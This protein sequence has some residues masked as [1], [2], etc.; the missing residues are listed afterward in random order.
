VN[1]G[2]DVGLAR[3]KDAEILEWALAN[4]S[5]AVTLDAD[6]REL[7]A[8]GA[9][10]APSVIRLR[11]QGLNADALC[12]VVLAVITS[13]ADPIARGAA[14]TANEHQARVRLLPIRYTQ[15]LRSQIWLISLRPRLGMN[16]DSS[17]KRR[18]S[19]H[20]PTEFAVHPVDVARV[21]V[22]LLPNPTRAASSV[23]RV[24]PA[25][26]VTSRPTDL[27]GGFID[28]NY[29]VA[30]C[31]CP[32]SESRPRRKTDTRADGVLRCSASIRSPFFSR[33]P[34]TNV[35]PPPRSDLPQG[36]S[37]TR[38]P[39]TRRYSASCLEGATWLL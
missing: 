10:V 39:I 28:D 5:V 37:G 25:L 27:L 3:A 22:D 17:T 34:R 6:F 4:G 21:A 9:A 35:L 18:R 23:T 1:H 7:L 26:R 31:P 32:V 33:E 20:R 36:R 14:V 12:G 2:D 8:R 11:V 29:G 19:G 30:P 24:K 38:Y 13:C 16:S 15:S